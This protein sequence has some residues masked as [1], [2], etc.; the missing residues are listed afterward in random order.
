[1]YIRKRL[2]KYFVEIKRQGHKII[3]KTFKQQS[4]AMKW[5][6]SVEIQLDQSRYKDTS[7]ASKTTLKSVMERHLKE[8][9]RVVREPKK[10]HQNPQNLQYLQKLKS[11]HHLMKQ[12]KKMKVM[13]QH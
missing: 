6:R 10:E 4:D 9:L 13:Q 12:L 1:M 5:G 2:G 8:R 11:L 3:Y 7:N